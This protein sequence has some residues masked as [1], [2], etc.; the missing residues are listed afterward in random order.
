MSSA[1]LVRCVMCK[2]QFEQIESRTRF[3]DHCKSNK[4]RPAREIYYE[5]RKQIRKGF[6]I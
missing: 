3:C 4:M 1:F 5:E 2:S 6:V